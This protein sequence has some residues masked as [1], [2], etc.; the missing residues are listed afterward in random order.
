VILPVV[1]E[2]VALT[3]PVRITEFVKTRD[4][5]LAG[6]NFSASCQLPLFGR[7]WAAADDVASATS[8][9]PKSARWRADVLDMSNSPV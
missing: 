1:T 4:R 3:Q 8:P 5:R 9:A 6:E 2:R 7:S